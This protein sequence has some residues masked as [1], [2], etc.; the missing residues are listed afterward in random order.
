MQPGNECSFNSPHKPVIIQS[1]STSALALNIGFLLKKL[2]QNTF[3]RPYYNSFCV[4]LRPKRTAGNIS[5]P[6]VIAIPKSQNTDICILFLKIHQVL[7]SASYSAVQLHSLCPCEC[8]Y[9]RVMPQHPSKFAKCAFYLIQL[10]IFTADESME[11]LFFEGKN[12]VNS[13][14]I[15]IICSMFNTYFHLS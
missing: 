10:K 12:E 3:K 2:H 13:V 1:T 4:C 14:S 5:F 11:T 6:C 9:A 7:F 15:T 8:I